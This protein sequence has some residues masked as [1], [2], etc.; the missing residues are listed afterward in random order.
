[1]NTDW[2]HKAMA[3]LVEAIPCGYHRTGPA[4]VEPTALALA[5]LCG[6]H[7]KGAAPTAS[8]GPAL[9]QVRGNDP[10][11]DMKLAVLREA[12]G[13]LF[14]AKSRGISWLLDQQN[15]DG[16]W[17]VTA[18]QRR[19]CWP[20]GWV[21]WTLWEAARLDR[22]MGDSEKPEPDGGR[23]AE[24]GFGDQRRMI[25]A[26]QRAIEWLLRTA[27]R[28]IKNA[29][30]DGRFVGH[31][32]QLQGWPWVDT[33]HSWVEPTAMALLA[34]R[35]VGRRDHPRYDEA[36]RLLLDR[37]L[38]NG[39]WNYGNTTVLGN[40]LRP[41][42]QPTGLALWALA[43]EPDVRR[44]VDRSIDYLR[45]S[46]DERTAT[47]SLSYAMIGLAAFAAAP[48]DADDWLAQAA[49]R[50]LAADAPPYQTALLLLAAQAVEAGRKA[51]H[52]GAP[53]VG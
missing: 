40:T 22:M 31:D 30:D 32:T 23:G 43:G 34:L 39:G 28:P 6:L 29:D 50:T 25:A 51:L 20:T 33:T 18:E 3:V 12:L 27:G 26:A 5:A 10:N 52:E 49:E 9:R 41:H 13:E 7:P 42:V 38:P 8:V 47:A 48:N 1:M 46:I 15:P 45:R 24:S 19:P 53:A 11:T 4:A 14:K 44:R 17:G 35:R 2:I 37:Q 21:V 16:S 36:V